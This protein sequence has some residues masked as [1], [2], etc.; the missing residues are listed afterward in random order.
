[1]PEELLG[2]LTIGA[3]LDK[4]DADA[5]ASYFLKPLPGTLVYRDN[6]PVIITSV[7]A[8]RLGLL[9]MN[10]VVDE[11]S[12]G[13]L[14]PGWF[15]KT[16]MTAVAALGKLK[17]PPLG[18]FGGCPDNGAHGTAFAALSKKLVDCQAK[19]EKKHP[20]ADDEEANAKDLETLC[21]PLAKKAEKDLKKAY[22]KIVDEF[23]EKK[24]ANALSHK[25][26]NW[27]KGQ[28]KQ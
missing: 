26:V 20:R 18:E 10:A 12:F 16:G 5:F 9:H 17:F 8:D 1:M 14:A 19:V 28:P 2:Y 24:P 22:D 13:K 11:V 21:A 7:G 25:W 6:E 3:Q 23:A 27:L 4:C 15:D